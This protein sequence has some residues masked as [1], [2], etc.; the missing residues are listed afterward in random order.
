MKV[1]EHSGDRL[2]TRNES[3]SYKLVVLEAT[4]KIMHVRLAGRRPRWCIV[5]MKHQDDGDSDDDDDDD[6]D[7]SDEDAEDEVAASSATNSESLG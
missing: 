1:P 6:G 7:E 5:G 2:E 4:K 3:G